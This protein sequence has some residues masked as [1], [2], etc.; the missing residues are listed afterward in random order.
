MSSAE[1]L[2]K[3]FV[4]L[5][6]CLLSS[7]I[8]TMFIL[9]PSEIVQKEI[10]NTG[11]GDAPPEWGAQTHKDIDFYM[12]LGYFLTYFLD[13]FGIGQFVWTAVRRQRYDMYGQP[14]EE[15]I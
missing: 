4:I 3:S 7:V 5:V 15:D 8:I 13:F 2:F 10:M 12:S 1:S 14:I 11:M 9:A 6:V